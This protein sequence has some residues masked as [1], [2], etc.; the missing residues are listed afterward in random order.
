MPSSVFR[1]RHSRGVGQWVCATICLGIA[2]GISMPLPVTHLGCNDAPCQIG[3]GKKAIISGWARQHNLDRVYLRSK[4]GCHLPVQILQW[5]CC[6]EIHRWGPDEHTL[7]NKDK[8]CELHLKR[9]C[10]DVKSGRIGF[11]NQKRNK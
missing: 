11:L 9:D 8:H 6:G 3:L 4:R 5:G 10:P 7:G 2:R 1:T